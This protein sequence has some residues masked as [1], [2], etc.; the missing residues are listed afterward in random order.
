[1]A[2][3]KIWPVRGRLDHPIDYAMNPEKTD[4]KLGRKELDSLEDVMNY[5]VNE[6]KTEKQFYVSG[7][8]CNPAIAR[9]QFQT[10]K[11]QFGKEG[12]IIAYHGYQSFAE[13]EVTPQQAHDIGMELA[14]TIWGEGYQVVVA[15]HLNT[16]CLHNHFVV[17]S[18]SFLDGKRCRKKQWTDISKINDEIC[19]K[20]QLDV[21][22]GHGRRIPY[23]LAKAE[24][25]GAPTRLNIAREAV[26]DALSVSCNL[27]ELKYN[28]SAMGYICQFDENRKY[29]TIRQEDWKRPIRL[30]RMGEEYSNE[31]I[32]Q[33]LRNNS[34][35]VRKG[36]VYS[37]IRKC[38]RCSHTMKK[39]KT[40]K[41]GGLRGLYYH[42]CY[43][44]GY[45]PKRNL[46]SYQISP[47]LRD[48][49][50]KLNEISK[51]VRLL[52]EYRIDDLQQL[53]DYKKEVNEKIFEVRAELNKLHTSKGVE[54]PRRDWLKDE[55]K[56]LRYQIIL[57][58]RIIHRNQQIK[59]K[60]QAVRKEEQQQKR[61]ER[62]K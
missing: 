15:T 7:I 13:G 43:L 62:I 55:L 49:L 61:K 12:G 56:K 60:L 6:E 1:M 51:E 26:D 46:M 37:G 4:A 53:F 52:Q 48:E 54:V 25:E 44:L 39:G 45:M 8:N 36:V 23:Q 22:E 47:A 58:E 50:I 2:V 34:P 21:V 35:E 38:R 9:K 42:Y 11:S 29:W 33:R 59:E 57:C 30:I 10:V 18:V 14:K 32:K 5:A 19:R 27:R 28:L 40:R 16:K 41:I 17:N 3:T 31:Q 20:Y 24:R